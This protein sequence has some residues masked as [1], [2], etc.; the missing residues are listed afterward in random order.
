MGL[1]FGMLAAR[2]EPKGGREMPA[3]RVRH[4]LPQAENMRTPWGGLRRR[5]QASGEAMTEELN[6]HDGGPDWAPMS[7]LGRMG[8]GEA[9][10]F[11]GMAKGCFAVVCPEA[12][13]YHLASGREPVFILHIP[14]GMEFGGGF[15]HGAQA[16]RVCDAL[17]DRFPEFCR[18]VDMEGLAK[19]EAEIIAVMRENGAAV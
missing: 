14:T 19:R 9:Q 6:P 12:M 7:C 3:P 15:K 8:P 13:G 11:D 5:A 1:W 2:N 18:P 17:L 16:Y 10:H 4:V